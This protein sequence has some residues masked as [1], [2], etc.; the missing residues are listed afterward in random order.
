MNRITLTVI[1]LIV[2][3]VLG[4]YWVTDWSKPKEFE[5][6]T[7]PLPLDQQ[8]KR[9]SFFPRISRRSSIPVRMSRLTLYR[10]V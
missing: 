6:A 5:D 3:G 10:R 2:L 1:I 8:M 7:R 4:Y 9:R